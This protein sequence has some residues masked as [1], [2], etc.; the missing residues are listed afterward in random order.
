MKKKISVLLATLMGASCLLCATA[1]GESN[2]Q[3]KEGELT[4][5]YFEGGYGSAWLDHALENYKA[6]NDGF[7]YLTIP[8]S[9]VTSQM[10][11]YL[12]SGKNLS[13]IYIIQTGNWAEWVSYGYLANLSDVYNATVQ[14]SKGSRQI[15]DYM[16]QELVS[17]YYM[18]K[19]AGQGDYLPWVLPEASISISIVYNEEYLLSTT[20]GNT[21]E[22]RYTKDTKW[23]ETPKTVDELLDYCNDLNA[24]TDLGA[25]FSAP[26]AWPGND[27]HWLKNL[28]YTWFAQYQGVHAVN[29]LNADVLAGEGSYYDFWNFASAEVWKMTGIQ[30]AIDTLKSIFVGSDGNY[31]NSH[32]FVKEHSVQDAEKK[33]VAGET[34][35]LVGGSFFYN[36]MRPYLDWKEDDG[37]PDYTFKMMYLPTLVNAEQNEDGSTKKMVFY[38]TDEVILV[39]AKATNLEMAKDFLAYLFNE[40]NNLYFTQVSGTMRPFD[41]NPIELAGDDYEW[42]PFTASVLDMYNN[43]DTRLYAYPAGKAKEDVSLI[44]R[45]KQPDIFGSLGWATYLSGIRNYTA[46]EV[47]ETG[48]GTTYKSVYDATFGDFRD[49]YNRY[50]E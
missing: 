27:S 33:L 46:E 21:K 13:D 48:Y 36:E 37:K 11:T 47:M 41:Y 18:Q 23:T 43:A 28:L 19:Y 15:K 7:K 38:S 12:E 16:D 40:E 3:A 44:Y 45:Y 30:V 35:M 49:W 17:R 42:D 24:R 8:D 34:A 31:K 6:E 26:F 14:T 9:T 22:G 2:G 25:D 10:N 39:P 5:R 1:C 32:E 29:E 20:H 50:Y 4:I